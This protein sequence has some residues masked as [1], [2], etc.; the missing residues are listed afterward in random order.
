MEAARPHD[1]R[2]K[3][4][5]AKGD[6][7]TARQ[8]YLRAYGCYRLGRYPAPNSPGKRESYLKYIESYLNAARSFD[9]PLEVVDSPPGGARLLEIPFKGRPGKRRQGHRLLPPPQER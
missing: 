9:P 1:E 2:A 4:A 3:Q 8:E 7:A 6:T 5:E